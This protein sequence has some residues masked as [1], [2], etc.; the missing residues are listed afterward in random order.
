[1]YVMNIRDLFDEILCCFERLVNLKMID[2]YHVYKRYLLNIHQH[3]WVRLV[4]VLQEK[5]QSN[6][7]RLDSLWKE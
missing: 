6:E 4:F 5:K 2:I 7:F 3:K 1:M